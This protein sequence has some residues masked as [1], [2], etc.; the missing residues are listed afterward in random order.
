MGIYLAR[1]ELHGA[2]VAATS[3]TWMSATNIIN[4]M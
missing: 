2:N 4:D 3:Q 1:T